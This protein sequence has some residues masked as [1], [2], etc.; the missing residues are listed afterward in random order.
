MSTTMIG[1]E[2]SF[3]SV[4]NAET[5]FDFHINQIRNDARMWNLM[6]RGLLRHDV[7]LVVKYFNKFKQQKAF[8]VQ[9]NY[10]TFYFMMTHFIRN[11]LKEKTQWALDELAKADLKDYGNQLPEMVNSLKNDFQVDPALAAKLKV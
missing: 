7:D 11:G 9:P 6:I 3:G 2:L 10:F 4:Y 8:G 5:L 1:A